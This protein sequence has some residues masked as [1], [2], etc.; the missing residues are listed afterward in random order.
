STV[1]GLTILV[2]IL[3]FLP[4][5]QGFL[6][7]LASLGFGISIQ[8]VPAAIGPLLWRKASTA[9]ALWSI[10]AGEIV[11]AAVYLFGSPFPM[12]P[13]ASGIIA[14]S[15]IFFGGSLLAKAKPSVIQ[16]EFHDTLIEKLYAEKKPTVQ[17]K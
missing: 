16:N 9:A 4:A 10:I 8:L 14:A 3:S 1:L 2:V 13:A 5:A 6:V 12:G 17:S 15:V 11:L 7:P